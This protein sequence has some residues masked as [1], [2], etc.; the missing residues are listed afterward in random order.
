ME[1]SQSYIGVDDSSSLSSFSVPSDCGIAEAHCDHSET[2]GKKS[3]MIAG[4]IVG[5]LLLAL[6]II[7]FV[8]VIRKRKKQAEEEEISRA[9]SELALLG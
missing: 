8:V 2:A 5:V 1:N 6:G 4:I 7:I 3:G 9:S